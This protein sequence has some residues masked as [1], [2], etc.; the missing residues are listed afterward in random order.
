MRLV[1]CIAYNKNSFLLS[2]CRFIQCVTC[3]CP[4][5][6]IGIARTSQLSRFNWG[7]GETYG[8]FLIM[9]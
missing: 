5:M 9:L 8:F 4:I 1:S 7:G 3:Q 6:Y 2:P